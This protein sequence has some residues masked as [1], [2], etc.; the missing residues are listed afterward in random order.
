MQ[1]ATLR[2]SLWLPLSLMAAAAAGWRGSRCPSQ[3]HWQQRPAAST[4]LTLTATA[5]STFT[6]RCLETRWA[7]RLACKPP[8]SNRQLTPDDFQRQLQGEDG[9]LTPHKY[10]QA[11][12]EAYRSALEHNPSLLQAATV[13]DVGCGTGILS[14]FAAR[15]GAARVIGGR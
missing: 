12:T 3:R 11:R 15:A 1:S 6:A 9:C 7:G 5:T 4:T 2:E 14:L 8:G 10:V 13:L